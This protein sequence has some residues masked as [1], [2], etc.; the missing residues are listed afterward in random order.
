MSASAAAG[1]VDL[2]IDPGTADNP[3]SVADSC[4]TA[5]SCL[6]PGLAAVGDLLAI[7]VTDASELKRAGEIRMGFSDELL[8]QIGYHVKYMA[9]LVDRVC[10]M[11]AAATY[12]AAKRKVGIFA[13]VSV[14]AAES[15]AVANLSSRRRKR[16]ASGS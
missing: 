12:Q 6:L 5:R 4:E 14:D 10:E 3:E 15:T 9:E 13:D 2:F 8:I 7:A 16:R 1:L 11:E